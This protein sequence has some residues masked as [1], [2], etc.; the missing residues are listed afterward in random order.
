M[1]LGRSSCVVENDINILFP[2]ILR[3]HNSPPL[4]TIPGHSNQLHKVRLFSYT[5]QRHLGFSS[6]L[7][8]YLSSKSRFVFLISLLRATSPVN[9]KIHDLSLR[10]LGQEYNYEIPVSVIFHIFHTVRLS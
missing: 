1:E 8:T 4:D 3:H 9:P 5:S 2:L 7:S 10:K 6:Y